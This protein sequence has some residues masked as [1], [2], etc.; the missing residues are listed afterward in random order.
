MSLNLSLP[1]TQHT[2]F[3]PRITVIDPASLAVPPATTP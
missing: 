3:S 1:V 2:D